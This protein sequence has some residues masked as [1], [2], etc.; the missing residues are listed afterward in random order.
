MSKNLRVETKELYSILTPWFQQLRISFAF[1]L[2]LLNFLL[3]EPSRENVIF[4]NYFQYIF[5]MYFV[6]KNDL[7]RLESTHLASYVGFRVRIQ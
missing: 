2:R 5:E 3:V 7:Q 1:Y 4:V 6:L